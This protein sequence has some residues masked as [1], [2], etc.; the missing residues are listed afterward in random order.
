MDYIEQ[1]VLD[2]SLR[3]ETSEGKVYTKI[4]SIFEKQ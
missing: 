3:L 4:H 2:E 1:K